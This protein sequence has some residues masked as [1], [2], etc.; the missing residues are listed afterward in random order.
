[1]PH[2]PLIR[3][4]PV[5]RWDPR[6]ENQTFFIQSAALHVAYY[7]LVFLRVLPVL[8]SM[9][10]T[11]RRSPEAVPVRYYAEYHCAFILLG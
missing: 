8:P 11:A 7:F 1:V 9:L 2:Y 4:F 10:P 6:R 3:F 5:R